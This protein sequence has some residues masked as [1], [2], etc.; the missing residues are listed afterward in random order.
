MNDRWRKELEE[1]RIPYFEEVTVRLSPGEYDEI[2]RI[3]G[4]VQHFIENMLNEYLYH[5]D[6]VD[7][8]IK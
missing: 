2:E 5:S 6:K 3:N 7:C 1:R 8:S 4:P